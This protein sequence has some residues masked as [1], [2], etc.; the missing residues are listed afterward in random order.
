MAILIL[1]IKSY[2]RYSLYV[3]FYQSVS[4]CHHKKIITGQN[5][6]DLKIEND[7]KTKTTSKLKT[8]SN[9]KR[10]SKEDNLKD[11]Y[12]L[13]IEDNTKNEDDL[14]IGR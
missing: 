4:H 3:C 9:M 2:P 6:D 13:K 7:P 1:I 10:T 12:D 11:E 8:N 14:K 5:E